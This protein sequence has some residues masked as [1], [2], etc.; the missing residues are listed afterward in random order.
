[1]PGHMNPKQLFKSLYSGKS[2]LERIL[3]SNQ[4]HK[5]AINIIC[6]RIS[7]DQFS[8][9]EN[10]LPQLARTNIS[11]TSKM[12]LFAIQQAVKQAGIC[13]KSLDKRLGLFLGNNNNL[14]SLETL[15][16]LWKSTELGSLSEN[17]RRS[18]LADFE[19]LPQ[20]H[21]TRLIA[22]E[23]SVKGRVMTF[24][25]ACTAGAIAIISAQRRIQSGELD[26]AICGSSEYATHPLI[27]LSFAK[28]GALSTKLPSNPGEVCRP[29]DKDRS[30]CLLAD[31]SAFLVLESIDHAQKR[32][33]NILA[34]LTG[35]S[36]QTEAHK[37]TS[38]KEDGY[39][40]A[41]CMENALSNAKLEPKDIQHINAHGTSTP[42]NDLAEG[43][44]I[45]HVFHQQK[46][47]RTQNPVPTVTSTK[48]ALGHSLGASGSVEA[49]LCIQSLMQQKTLPTLNYHQPGSGESK[50]NIVTHGQ[51]QNINHVMSNSFGFGGENA[52][53]IF[54]KNDMK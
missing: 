47:D 5:N 21:A 51:K 48:S 25:D 29:F 46:N 30:G 28:L 54:S 18:I 24:G 7:K 2:L 8:T 15:S 19:T 32:G 45:E 43:R 49:L 42:S 6:S 20:S 27:Q 13:T 1:M 50:L 38:T 34:Y 16:D 11:R 41:K 40:Y 53:L 22:R 37:V 52:C 14:T 44:A 9:I 23:L 39:Y 33:A 10:K 35:S 31:G 26:V 3:I 4:N 17:S 12:S 36:R